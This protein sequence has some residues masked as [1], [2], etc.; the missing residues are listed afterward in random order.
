MPEIKCIIFDFGGV[1]AKEN[2]MLL[3]RG[4]N[5]ELGKNVFSVKSAI[6]KRAIAGKVTSGE[7]Y[8]FLSKEYGFSPS[9]LRERMNSK[10]PKFIEIQKPVLSLAKR[11]KSS[12]Y[13]I[14]ILSNMTDSSKKINVKRGV[15][16]YFSSVVLSCDM[17]CMKPHRKIYLAF[18]KMS[19]LRPQECI[20]IDNR[21]KN[22]YYPKKL[23]MKTV[24]YKNASQ[25]RRDLA[26]HGVSL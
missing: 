1:L 23:G 19:K 20:F 3:Y 4:L 2:T 26:R 6:F 11:L 12:G 16:G 8:A 5:E 21:K 15:F 22:F 9:F 14:S 17:K 7:F 13:K 24:H 25:L 18:L 10:Y